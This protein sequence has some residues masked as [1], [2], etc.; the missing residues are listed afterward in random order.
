[1]ACAA[2]SPPQSPSDRRY[3]VYYARTSTHDSL[4]GTK[5]VLPRGRWLGAVYHQNSSFVGYAD[6]KSDEMEGSD[7]GDRGYY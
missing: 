3:H 5:H 4:V 2:Q 1:M 6:Y 7:E